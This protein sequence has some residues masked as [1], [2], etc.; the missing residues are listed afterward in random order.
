MTASGWWRKKARSGS[1][2]GPEG[3]RPLRRALGFQTRTELSVF[4]LA[5]ALLVAVVTKPPDLGKQ[6]IGYDIDSSPVAEE[7]V[8]AEISFRSEIRAATQAKRDAAAATVPD[9]YAV[10]MDR[11][12]RQLRLLDE[13]IFTL[14][15]KRDD[16]EKAVRA[17]LTES[18]NSQEA[19]DVVLEAVLE[20]AA[21]LKEQPEFEPYPDAEVLATWLIPA[22][23]S[24]PERRFEEPDEN[25]AAPPQA[26]GVT[27]LAGAAASDFAW[28]HADTLDRL[29]HE[30]LEYVLSSGIVRSAP[31]PEQAERTVV[32]IRENPVG[33][34]HV[35]EELPLG[36][37]ATVGDAVEML[38]ARIIES[39][40]AA[41][42]GSESPV[43]WTQ[44]Q[45]AAFEMARPYVTHT[46]S[47][48][49]VFTEGARQ[50]ARR[51]A[52]PEFKEWHTGEVIQRSGDRWTAQSRSDVRAYWAELE[53]QRTS[54]L[55]GPATVAA[56]VILVTLV[57]ACLKRSFAFLVPSR[58]YDV[59][60][61]YLVL[62]VM[63]A[64]LV[65]G[66]VVWYFEPTGFVLP[67]A[68]GAI[69]LAILVNARVAVMAGTLTALLLSIQFGYGW[70]LLL[71]CSAM[72]V[73]GVFG[74]YRVRRRGDITRAALKA[75]VVGLL[76]A[77]AISLALDSL[78]S[79][80]A[81]RR[82]ALVLLNGLACVFI[83]PGVLSP[84]E[85]LFGITTDIQLLEYSD[86]NNAILS[87]MAIEMP[88]TY[89][90]SLMLGH[91]VEAA[92]DAI[93]ANGLL[94]R[95]CAYY[96][97]IGK[98]R[99]PEYYSE[100]QDGVNVH[101]ALPPRLSA[102]AIAL[103]VSAGVEV[104]REHHLPKP[105]I[106][107]IREH[108]GT[109]Q[110]S[111]FYQ[112]AVKEG[113]HDD[114]RE[115]DFR[116]PGPKPQ[117]REAAILMICDAVESGVRS[118][119]SPNEERVREFVDKIIRARST[120]RQFDECHLTL[121][122]LDVIKEAVTRRMVTALHTRIAYPDKEPDRQV[123]NVV[124]ITGGGA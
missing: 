11:L 4:A 98:L 6:K 67:V 93:G 108:H 116:Y 1:G 44:L 47:Y 100:N 119:K 3:K 90:H 70:R 64:T 50:R 49:E 122:D 74:M 59:R 72:S 94:A 83:V 88:A 39:A 76:V 8:R 79:E 87:R 32:I 55:R 51:E 63:C 77:A 123:D 61:L 23:G 81:L 38:N 96:H 31:P 52:A 20:Y 82:L 37:A 30:G 41:A 34:Q 103:H 104:A 58:K 124:S 120:D 95:V 105:I 85:R 107:G 75:T 35:S 110:I 2:T 43:D 102:R 24:L 22:V 99:R 16:V 115:E 57:L 101:D 60:L 18:D 12:R 5:L 71:V 14:R 13:H 17:A 33:D 66:R 10:D 54:P 9:T 45:G 25:A 73:A 68:A 109:N 91:L 92:A 114:V 84:L 62:L 112:Q 42:K 27:E 21:Q 97:D 117:S 46:L 106:D 113:K 19:S 111:F 28:A 36:E 29:A 53:A 7:E 26:L 89:A 118:I 121:K 86:L 65:L 80:P 69:L 78:T 15:D 56:H 40:K 48:D